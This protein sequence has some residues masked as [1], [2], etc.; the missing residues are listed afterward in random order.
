MEKTIRVVDEDGNRYEATYLKRAKGLVKH[1]RARFIEEDM[2]CLAC[3][4]KTQNISEEITMTNTEN[5][6]LNT[7]IEEKIQKELEIQAVYTLEYALA[8]IEKITNSVISI[9]LNEAFSKMEGASDEQM[10]NM[11]DIVRARETTNQR[12]LAIY[13]KMVDDLKPKTEAAEKQQ[14][15]NW[16][17]DCT[18]ASKAGAET[19]DYARIWETMYKA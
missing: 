5:K 11:A 3:P 2:I 12:L 13:E 9:N 1:G 4:P 15:L 18:A 17:R 8:Q 10:A 6:N 19:P 14:F 16:V 7:V